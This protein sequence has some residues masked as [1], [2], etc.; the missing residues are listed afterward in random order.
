MDIPNPAGKTLIRFSVV[1]PS[2]NSHTVGQ[3]IV[4]LLAQTTPPY[5]I[6]VVGLDPYNLI[7]DSERI[8]FDCTEI[9][10]PPGKARNRGAAKADGDILV[11]I[12]ADCIARPN[13]LGILA[14]RFAD[15]AVA[16]VGGGVAIHSSNYWTLSDNISMFHEYLPSK[17]PG[18]RKQLPSINL[19]VRRQTFLDIGRFDEERRTGEDSDLTIRLQLKGHTL[20]FEPSAVVEHVPTRDS[21]T[22]LISHN[23]LHGQ[24]SV[25]FDPRYGDQ[26]GLYRLFRTKWGMILASPFLAAGVTTRIFLSDQSLW[27]YWYTAPAIFL[28]KMAWCFGA[29][30]R[31]HGNRSQ[32]V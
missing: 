29:A 26:D 15:P 27:R 3:T 9:P 17:P 11:F 6:I 28:A 25:K 4:S 22:E 21:L 24:Q 12:D 23:Y 10:F 19:A 1:I 18:T 8:H 30:T 2:L 14:E 31:P 13:W 7:F 16:V 20:F 5:E 32:S